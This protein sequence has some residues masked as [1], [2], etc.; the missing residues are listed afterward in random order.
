M[1]RSVQI[2]RA[3]DLDRH[4]GLEAR[5]VGLVDGGHTAFKANDTRLE[6]E[7]AVKVIRTENLHAARQ[8]L[9]SLL[10][11]LRQIRGLCF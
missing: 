1:P 5:V 4:L 7:V 9:T 3:D 11:R 2:F 10:K 8:V 6:A